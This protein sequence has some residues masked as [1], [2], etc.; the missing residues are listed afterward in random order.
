MTQSGTVTLL[1]TDLV[2]STELLARTGDEH[3]QR[4]FDAH[5]ELLSDAVTANGGAEVKWLGDGLMVAFPSAADAV[6]CAIAMQESAARAPG[7]RLSLRVGLHVGEAI[8]NESDYFGTAVVIARRLCERAGAGQILCS[9]LVAGLLA[10]RQAFSFR[11]LGALELKGFST[12]VAACEVL[13]QAGAPAAPAQSAPSASPA[14]GRI[15][16]GR[17]RL[18]L[19]AG[20][21]AVIVAGVVL[22]LVRLRSPAPAP[23]PA[24][25]QTAAKHTISSIAVLPLD[26]FSG[27]PKQEYFA[28]GMTDEL[29][30]DLAKIS[31]LRVIS[32]GSV[33]RY[34]GAQRPPTPEIAK[35]LNV[36]AVVEGSVMRSGDKVRITAQLID[37]PSDKHL[38][39]E[40]YE[41]ETRDVLALQDEVAL[42]IAR[43]INVELTPNE[44]VRFANAR[45]VNPQAYEA[46]L[47]GR[48]Y[49]NKWTED[50][51]K[52][53]IDYFE[54][55]IKADPT[56]A[57]AYAALADSYVDASDWYLSSLEAVPQ[58]GSQQGA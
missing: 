50:G 45:P 41:R 18:A 19:I 44:Q 48:Y 28:D 24:P 34:K 20:A 35:A 29:T 54:Q 58:G 42:A 2:N 37:A 46:Y 8:K 51:Y 23:A 26:N 5:H 16:G 25:A 13:Y 55:A 15:S 1:F 31:A 43:E 12:P 4:I 11:E 10:G 14:T 30:T 53:A 7:E 6:R 47:K 9:A 33:M 40:S 36:D 56:F 27:D 17:R 39:A 38:W 3:A 57:A 52:R 32:R 22:A 49:W 21:G